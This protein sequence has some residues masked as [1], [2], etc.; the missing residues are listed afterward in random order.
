MTWVLAGNH[1]WIRN[2]ADTYVVDVRVT[3]IC[4]RQYIV[5]MDHFFQTSASVGRIGQQLTDTEEAGGHE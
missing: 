1:S 2:S 3:K 4:S 5:T